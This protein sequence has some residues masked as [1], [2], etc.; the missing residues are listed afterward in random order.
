[1]DPDT[2]VFA[3]TYQRDPRA[4]AVRL[5]NLSMVAASVV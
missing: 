5:K 2:E 4:A 3:F 1:M